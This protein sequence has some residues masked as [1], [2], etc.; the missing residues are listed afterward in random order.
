MHDDTVVLKEIR[1]AF[2]NI[3]GKGFWPLESLHSVE[4]Y[5]LCIDGDY[6]VAVPMDDLPPVDETF[7]DV[8]FAVRDFTIMHSGETKS[9]LSLTSPMPQSQYGD[10]FILL[11]YD[12]LMWV[13]SDADVSADPFVWWGDWKRMVGN[14]DRD[15]QTY[16]IVAEMIVLDMMQ[17][18][19]LNPTWEG[20]K[21]GSVDIRSFNYDCEVKSSLY[22]YNY[23]VV[24]SSQ[25]QLRKTDRDLHLRYICF[26]Q[27]ESGLSVEDMVGRL[28][29]HGFDVFEIEENLNCL[30]LHKGNH[31]RT[32]RYAPVRI[33]DFIV[34][35]C[36]PYID[37]NSFVGG[38]LPFAVRRFEYVINLQELDPK[39]LDYPLR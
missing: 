1:S 16:P 26:E 21:S 39:S 6:G 5:F 29:S 31:S 36:F 4:A 32:I 9:C 37:E 33:W 23:E 2:A 35:D 7:S 27:S 28:V 18:E 17:S 3:Q 19:G 15:R 34:D 30:G 20:P 38:H 22:R 24:I 12:F 10:K 11:C 13:S 14:S 25:A 8:R